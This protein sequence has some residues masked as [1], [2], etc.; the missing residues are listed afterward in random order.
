MPTPSWALFGR[1]PDR[2]FEQLFRV[3]K[4]LLGLRFAIRMGDVGGRRDITRLEVDALIMCLLANGSSATVL[5]SHRA[6]DAK[7]R[8]AP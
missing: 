6:L 3:D 4:W 5:F 8:I 1:V 7:A 2:L